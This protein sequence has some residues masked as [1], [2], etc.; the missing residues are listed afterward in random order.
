MR[1]LVVD[2]SVLIRLYVPDGPL[3]KGAEAAMD[4]AWRG[5]AMIVAPELALAEAAQVLRKKELAGY[6]SPDECDEILQR[7]LELPVEWLGHRNHLV[8]A[9]GLSRTTGLTA[10]DALFVA[11]AR[12]HSAELL[13]AD[14][15]ML[16]AYQ[17][18][19]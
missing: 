17:T 14:E 18:S 1:R 3:P 2:T 19:G 11:L 7:I 4:S 13:S 8:D 6:L 15:E 10:Y 16:A 5:D 12:A 9:V